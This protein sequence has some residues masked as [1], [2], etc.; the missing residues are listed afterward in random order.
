MRSLHVVSLAFHV[1]GSFAF[2]LPH[3]PIRPGV[4][5]IV[6]LVALVAPNLGFEASKRLLAQ[7]FLPVCLCIVKLFASVRSEAAQLP[8]QEGAIESCN[9]LS[10]LPPD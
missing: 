7:T 1:S 5:L 6:A 3:C 4:L 10:T 2:S 8:N 9:F